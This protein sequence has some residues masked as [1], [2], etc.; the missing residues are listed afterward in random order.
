LEQRGTEH[1]ET[2]LDCPA[3]H[4]APWL[5][6]QQGLD[7]QAT[8][9]FE[10]DVLRACIEDFRAKGVNLD[11]YN[12]V[13]NAADVNAAREALGYDQII[14]Y[15][16]SYGA[17]LGQHLM[18]DFPDA[19]AGV[20][21]DGANAL[22][23]KSWIEDR[24]LDAQWGID[25]LTE[26]CQAD[27]KCRATY[28]IPALVDS[29]LKLLDAGPM[30]FTYSDPQDPT[31][32]VEVKLNKADLAAF[33]FAQQASHITAMSLPAELYQFTQDGGSEVMRQALG[34]QKAAGLLAAREATKGEMAIVQHLA[35]VCSDDPVK[36]ADDL[37]VEG[38]SDY[39][40][41]Y[42]RSAGEL[43]V[44]AC[45]L[46]GV[47]ELPDST[48]VDVRSEVPTLLLAGALDVSTPAFRTKAVA[49]DLPR[50]T[51]VTFPDGTHVQVA[52]ANLCALDLLKQFVANPE[53]QLDL[54]C[55]EARQILP[56]VLPD[57]T[58]SR[59]VE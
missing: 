16:A 55:V 46:I 43:Y 2:F 3:V 41:T 56:F 52:G 32:S 59:E 51:M 12:S 28:D 33:I 57:G 24:A 45:P 20:I 9:A 44:T 38:V 30:T 31:V 54:S 47:K 1:T 29:A 14:Y 35:M 34:T 11:A 19:L 8:E 22:S 39:A 23:R 25:N 36:S 7:D 17:Q 40:V 27:E 58:M 6:H 48:D 18:R 26:L 21:L 10:V 49:D 4:Q 42:G 50:A 15:G 37:I 13:E 53:G 5:V